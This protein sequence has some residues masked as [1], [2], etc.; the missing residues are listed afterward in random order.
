MEYGPY[1]WTMDRMDR[2]DRMD[3]LESTVDCRGV[4]VDW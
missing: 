1:G 4:R 3:S 2:M